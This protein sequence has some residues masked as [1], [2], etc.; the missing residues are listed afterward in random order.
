M[1]KR[2]LTISICVS[3]LAAVC[4]EFVAAPCRQAP[5]CPP[6]SRHPVSSRRAVLQISEL[7]IVFLGLTATCD[8]E[9]TLPNC[10]SSS[11]LSGFAAGP[12]GPKLGRAP[13]ALC[14]HLFFSPSDARAKYGLWH[15]AP[16]EAG[17]ARGRGSPFG[18]CRHGTKNLAPSCP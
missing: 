18:E 5:P 13:Y 4:S 3:V 16:C 10:E 2:C 7:F 14:I 6:A 9:K 12:T 15:R 11:Q 17:A 8:S 1:K